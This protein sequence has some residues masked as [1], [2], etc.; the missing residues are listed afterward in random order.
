MPVIE[1]MEF[2]EALKT[3]DF[4]DKTEVVFLLLAM[5]SSKEDIK[6]FRN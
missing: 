4:L 5:N 1:G 6:N 3:I 2:M